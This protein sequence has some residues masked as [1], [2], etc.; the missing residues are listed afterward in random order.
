M[1]SARQRFVPA[2]PGASS[3]ELYRKLL[4]LTGIR[5]LVG[6]AL[7]VATAFLTLNPEA[8]GFPRRVEAFGT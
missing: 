2:P 6:T 4:L 5:L 7:L 1:D 8:E 3:P